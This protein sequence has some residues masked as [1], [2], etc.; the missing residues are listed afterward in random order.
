MPWPRSLKQRGL[1]S[2]LNGFAS[3]IKCLWLQIRWPFRY[4][5]FLLIFSWAS[6][7]RSTVWLHCGCFAGRWMWRRSRRSWWNSWQGWSAA[8]QDR[9]QENYWP[10]ISPP[11][12][13][14]ATRSLFSR[15]WINAMKSLRAKMT[16]PHTCQQNCKIPFN[17]SRVLVFF[18]WPFFLFEMFAFRY[19]LFRAAFRVSGIE[20]YQIISKGIRVK[21]NVNLQNGMFKEGIQCTWADSMLCFSGNEASVVSNRVLFIIHLYLLVSIQL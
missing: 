21:P 14:S 3:W 11:S 5:F 18:H 15:L 12:T 8:L 10:K 20:S 19:K 13:A 1:S 2:S 16:H 9:P 6:L 4:S 7:I 17:C